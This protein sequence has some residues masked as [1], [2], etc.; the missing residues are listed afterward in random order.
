MRIKPT[1]IAGDLNTALTEL[2]THISKNTTKGPAF[3]LA[4]RQNLQKFI[5]KNS[6]ID[7]YRFK[8]P[9]KKEFTWWHIKYF[10]R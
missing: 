2:D 3:T 5:S 1:I 10:G 9:S 6:L 8:N 4:E 7:S